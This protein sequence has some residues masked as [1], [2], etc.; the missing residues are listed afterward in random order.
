[1]L[2]ASGWVIFLYIIIGLLFGIIIGAMPGLSVVVAVAV[3]FPITMY[4]LP[5]HGI[6]LLSSIYTGGVYGGG[7]TAIALN[8]PGTGAAVATG[9]DGY[10]MTQQGDYYLAVGYGLMSSVIGTFFGYLLLLLV[11]RPLGGLVLFFG[12]P[13]MLMLAVFAFTIIGF[14]HKDI[15]SS[16]IGGILGLLIGSIGMSPVGSIRGTFGLYQLIDGIPFVPALVGLFAISEAFIMLES[17]YLY[18]VNATKKERKGFMQVFEGVIGV[19]KYPMATIRSL[20]IG[21]VVGVI[22]AAGSTIASIISYGQGRVLSKKAALFGKGSPEGVICAETANNA[23][24]AGAMGTL[25]CFG[26]PG[27]GAT[28]ILLGAFMV[29]GINPGP[30]LIRE[31]M[32]FAYAIILSNFIQAILLFFIALIVISFIGKAISV[33]TSY[34]VPIIISTSI[35]GS[36]AVRGIWLDVI[37]LLIFGIIGFVMRKLN[38]PLITIILGLLLSGILERE[39]L[40][41]FRSFGYRPFE[42][43][44]SPIVLIFIVLII[45]TLL[46]PKLK[47]FYDSRKESVTE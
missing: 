4:M 8:I 5:L 43:L 14:V 20:L 11:F 10:P 42:I 24:E 9:F 34:L 12:P 6:V 32:G 21:L 33:P 47:G 44:H 39:A 41:T 31:H 35:I 25:L 7:L 2:L 13:E 45:L 29:H 27:S 37:I 16:L 17:E 36:F 22:P 46:G 23:S 1:M 26:I 30:Y 40:R 28:A 38:Y 3:V 19:F 15:T 18:D